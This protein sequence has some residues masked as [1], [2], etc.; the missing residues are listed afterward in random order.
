MNSSNY[1]F[2]LDIHSRQSQVSIPV[3]Q[4]DT[5]RSLYISLSDG[6]E[7]YHIADGCRA[8]LFAKKADE[9]TLVHD[10]IIEWNSNIRYDFTEQTATAEGITECEVRLYGADGRLITSPRFIMVVDA[11][12]VIDDVPISESE[13]TAL[14]NALL[15]ETER[16]YAETKR[17]EAE[18]ERVEAE[19]ARVTAEESRVSAE[20]ERVGAEQTR[21]ENESARV[22][23]EEGRA[24]AESLRVS[25]ERIRA[26]GETNRVSAENARSNAETNRANAETARA[27]AESERNSAENERRAAMSALNLAIAEANTASN[28]ANSVADLVEGLLADTIPYAE[29][30]SY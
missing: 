9:N 1:R 26:E 6:G 14:D 17:V 23:A 3:M 19:S 7:A 24:S 21:I 11:R 29:E 22:T 10:C 12:V 30:E 13:N 5:G 25:S 28:R 15:A 8:V 18:A 16:A 2:S 27:N 20:T 4:Y